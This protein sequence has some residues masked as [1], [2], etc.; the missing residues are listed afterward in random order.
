MRSGFYAGGIFRFRLFIPYTF[1]ECKECPKLIFETPLFHP[2]VNS[3]TN[4]L[5]LGNNCLFTE[6]QKDINHLWQVICYMKTIFYN[7]QTNC[8]IN[9]LAADL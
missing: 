3:L 6:W 1:P 8:A 9:Q 7:I 5:Y 4:E 2:Y